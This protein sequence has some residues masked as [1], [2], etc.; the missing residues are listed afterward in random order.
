M[1]EKIFQKSSFEFD[2]FVNDIFKFINDIYAIDPAILI[3]NI[4]NPCMIDKEAGKLLGNRKAND[5]L[6]ELES[7]KKLYFPFTQAKLTS[8]TSFIKSVDGTEYTIENNLENL[9]QDYDTVGFIV[10]LK[11][12]NL[13]FKSG[14]HKVIM[15]SDAAPTE[16]IEEINNNEYEQFY[17]PMGSFLEKFVK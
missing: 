9:L 2:S 5:L 15:Q 13:Q 3:Q 10:S 6:K 16:K 14:V 12:M 11:D 4:E 17:N 7:G 1:N 8:E